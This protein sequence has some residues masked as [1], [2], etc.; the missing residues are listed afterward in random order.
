M[1]LKKFFKVCYFCWT[2]LWLFPRR[3]MSYITGRDS[4]LDVDDDDWD[5]QYDSTWEDED[6]TCK[7]KKSNLSTSHRNMYAARDMQK[8][9][10]SI[11][12]LDDSTSEVSMNIVPYGISQGQGYTQSHSRD[13]FYNLEFYKGSTRSVPDGVSIDEFHKYW[14]GKYDR[15]ERVHSYIQWL[16]PLQEEGMN[17][18]AHVLT[19]EEIKQFRKDKTAK[20]NLLKS[21]ELM[22]DFYGIRLVNDHTGAVARANNWEERFHNLNRNTHNNLRITRILKCL[23]TLG[24]EHFQEKLVR[25]FLHETL[26]E[27]NLPNVKLS[28][29]DYFIFAVLDKSQ[30]QDLIKFAFCKYQP[31]KDFVWG[32]KKILSRFCASNESKIVSGYEWKAYEEREITPSSRSNTEDNSRKI[33]NVQ[34]SESSQSNNAMPEEKTGVSGDQKT[35]GQSKEKGQ[36]KGEDHQISLKSPQGGEKNGVDRHVRNQHKSNIRGNVMCEEKS[37]GEINV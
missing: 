32:P 16:F 10:R 13:R 28:V 35:S 2:F 20:G 19:K 14:K 5:C 37:D 33:S 26:V 23:G 8:F 15:L 29:L 1:R 25:F 3:V 7:K 27:K 30:R 6:K 31:Q 4:D 34:K 18:E 9:R 36:V 24:F 22:L 21:Y 12:N 17:W 11:R